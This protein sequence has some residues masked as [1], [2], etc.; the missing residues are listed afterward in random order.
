MKGFEPPVQRG[1]VKTRPRTQRF[2]LGESGGPLQTGVT[3][4]ELIDAV[5]TRGDAI[6]TV[7]TS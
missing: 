6:A 3:V 7:D 2:D 1:A 4:W 5:V